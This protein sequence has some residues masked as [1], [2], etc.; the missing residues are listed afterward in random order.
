L[1]APRITG[2]VC[3]GIACQPVQ[4]VCRVAASAEVVIALVREDDDAR[5]VMEPR[6]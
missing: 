3:D 6:T 5:R 1:C 4:Q 2:A